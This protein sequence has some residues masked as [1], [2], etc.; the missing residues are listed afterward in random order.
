MGVLKAQKWLQKY[1]LPA[2]DEALDEAL[3]DYIAR[4]SKEI[5]ETG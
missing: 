1:E 2:M 3:L 5:S 4:R